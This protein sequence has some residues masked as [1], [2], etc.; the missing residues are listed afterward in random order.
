MF[1]L[2][3]LR[4]HFISFKPRWWGNMGL[5][6]PLTDTLLRIFKVKI[7]KAR[8]NKNMVYD[9]IHWDQNFMWS[10]H[11]TPT[12]RGILL[13][14]CPESRPTLFL[15]VTPRRPAGS[16]DLAEWFYFTKAKSTVPTMGKQGSSSHSSPTGIAFIKFKCCWIE[17]HF[18]NSEVHTFW[19]VI[20]LSD[21]KMCLPIK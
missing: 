13:A 15:L 4:Y 20:P 18:K 19:T 7:F 14:L 6:E 17:S 5:G 11:R 12:P 8:I 1:I 16:P 3:P 2:S 9:C 21:F 10:K